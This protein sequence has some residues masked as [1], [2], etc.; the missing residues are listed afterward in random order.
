M[1][2]LNEIDIKVLKIQVH[3][4]FKFLNMHPVS[5]KSYLTLSLHINIKFMKIN[6]F[7]TTRFNKAVFQNQSNVQCTSY[8]SSNI[9]TDL[10]KNVKHIEQICLQYFNYVL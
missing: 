6:M 10:L 8:H 1:E 7:E 3:K 9:V 5:S 4:Y 2:H